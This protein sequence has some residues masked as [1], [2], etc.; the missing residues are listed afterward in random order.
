MASIRWSRRQCKHLPTMSNRPLT[1]SYF[2]YYSDLP[3]E[4][5][6]V[7]VRGNRLIVVF[8]TNDET[9]CIGIQFPREDLTSFRADIAGN[10]LNV[11]ELVPELAARVRNATQA[12]RFLG[13]TNIPNFFRKPY[14]PGRALVGDAGYHKDPY[15]AQGISDAFFS[16][17][18]LAEA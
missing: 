8:P 9:T 12:E 18:L 11:V 13:V 5:T 6:A 15:T 4:E 3:V 16:A 1:C 2:T 14:G 10:F 17:K 7:Y